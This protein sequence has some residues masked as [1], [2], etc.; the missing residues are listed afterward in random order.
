MTEKKTGQYTSVT[1]ICTDEHRC[2]TLHH[3]VSLVN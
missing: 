3:S 1:D 2:F